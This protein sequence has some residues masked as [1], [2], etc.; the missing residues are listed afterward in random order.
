VFQAAAKFFVKA[1]GVKLPPL[2]EDTQ[3]IRIARTFNQQSLGQIGYLLEIT[4]PRG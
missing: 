2:C 1:K 3:V 4:I